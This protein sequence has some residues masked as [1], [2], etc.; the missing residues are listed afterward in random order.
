MRL[1][2]IFLVGLLTMSPLGCTFSPNPLN[3]FKSAP[4][5]EERFTYQPSEAP[6]EEAQQEAVG[7]LETPEEA[8]ARPE[9]PEEALMEREVVIKEPPTFTMV[10]Y[11]RGPESRARVEAAVKPEPDP[12]YERAKEAHAAHNVEEG[13]Y[14]P[15]YQSVRDRIKSHWNFLYSDIEGISYRTRDDLP[16]TVEARIS[17][18]GLVSD[19][20]IAENAGNAILAAIVKGAIET[21]LLDRFPPEIEDEFIRLSVQFYFGE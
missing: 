6:T 21:A 15:Y 2:F 12:V 10:Y 14:A 13:I 18:T 1:T 16:I 8:L 19:L 11:A 20:D 4:E 9:A 17:P 3:W 5:E 7:G